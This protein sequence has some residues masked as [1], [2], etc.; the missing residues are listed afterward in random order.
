MGIFGKKQED[1]TTPQGQHADNQVAGMVAPVQSVSAPQDSIDGV[2][3][4]SD[5]GIQDLMNPGVPP[6]QDQPVEDTASSYI[7]ADPQT[8]QNNPEDNQASPQPQEEAPQSEDYIEAEVLSEEQSQPEP[9]EEPPVHAEPIQITE[10]VD[11]PSTHPLPSGTPNDLTEIREKALKDL[12]PLV[13]HLDQSPEER[14]HTAM[15]MLQATDDHSLVKTAY[16]AA[17]E[18]TDEKAKAQALLDI[19]NEINYFTQKS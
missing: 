15:M 9:A 8:P 19:V 17:Q 2:L 3:S 16:E 1:G 13:S 4:S 18:I 14:F 6:V 5:N 10:P 12:S 7:M 11:V